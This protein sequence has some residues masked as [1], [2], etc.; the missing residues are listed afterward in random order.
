[1]AFLPRYHPMLTELHLPGWV[2]TSLF[3]STGHPDAQPR[4]GGVLGC[5]TYLSKILLRMKPMV[6]D[7]RSQLCVGS[8]GFLTEDSSYGFSKTLAHE[9]D[10]V[11]EERGWGQTGLPKWSRARNPWTEWGSRTTSMADGRWITGGEGGGEVA[12]GLYRMGRVL[13]TSFCSSIQLQIFI[14]HL[15]YVW[16]CTSG[17]AAKM[18]IQQDFPLYYACRGK[19]PLGVKV[20]NTGSVLGWAF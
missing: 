18:I 1:M 3:I 9:T 4:F 10:S 8:S 12:D 14:D 6:M 17:N 5:L 11:C 16:L 13:N 19:G 15:I 2:Q 20:R 7:T